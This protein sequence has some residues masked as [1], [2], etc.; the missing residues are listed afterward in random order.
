MPDFHESHLVLSFCYLQWIM[1]LPSFFKEQKSS[2]SKPYVAKCI[3]H[4]LYHSE[5]AG[6]GYVHRNIHITWGMEFMVLWCQQFADKLITF[7]RLHFS[8]SRTRVLHG[9][10]LC[11]QTALPYIWHSRSPL[12]VCKIW[13][14]FSNERSLHWT[15]IFTVELLYQ[16]LA[17]RPFSTLEVIY[18]DFFL[19][20]TLVENV[21]SRGTTCFWSDGWLTSAA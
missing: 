18:L 8:I 2:F 13:I 4:K 15:F 16:R 14:Q 9:N 10:T 12:S 6:E 1:S 21:C 7:A 5:L 19:F 17:N 20:K 11:R 3:S